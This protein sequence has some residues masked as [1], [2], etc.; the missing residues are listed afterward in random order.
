MF[1][2]MNSGSSIGL[3]VI[4]L[5]IFEDQLDL[6][7]INTM[8]EIESLLNNQLR[9]LSRQVLMGGG[10][11]KASAAK[12]HAIQQYQTFNQR[13][14]AVRFAEADAALTALKAHEK[15]LLKVPRKKETP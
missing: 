5:D 3:T 9:S 7:K 14:K 12:A 1:P 10:T 2:R 4:L 6:G 15:A 13:R 11:V 8:A